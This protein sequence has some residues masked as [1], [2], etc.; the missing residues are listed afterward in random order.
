MTSHSQFVRFSRYAAQL[1]IFNKDYLTRNKFYSLIFNDRDVI[2]Q[3]II[4]NVLNVVRLKIFNRKP[5][6]NFC[7]RRTE[8]TDLTI[9][10]LYDDAYQSIKR[11][12]H[13]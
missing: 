7:V 12:K 3:E 6:R 4:Y 8:L 1:P 11:S 13:S 9:H 10:M 2:S 5:I